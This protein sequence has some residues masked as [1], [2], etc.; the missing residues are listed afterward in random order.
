MKKVLIAFDFDGVLF[1]NL[2]ERF[3]VALNAFNAMGSNLKKTKK[4]YKGYLEGPGFSA[5]AS[6]LYLYFKLFF[7]K[8]RPPTKKEARQAKIIL[9]KQKEFFVKL[10]YLEREKLVK[11]IGLKK[12]VSLHKPFLKP[13][14]SFKK[15]V[16][17]KRFVV[18]IV[19]RKD[20]K[21]VKRLLKAFKINLGKNFVFSRETG[22]NK[23]E[24]LRK[25]CKTFGIPLKKT[26][27]ID[28][29]VLQ[30]FHVKKIGV[31][32]VL[33]GW[34]YASKQELKKARKKGVKVLP[35]NQIISFCNNFYLT[36]K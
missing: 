27:L 30:V 2:Y 12:W 28:D 25:A 35:K 16:Q 22:K 7:E 1:D 15:L 18:I 9:E 11:K 10:F 20:F 5:D 23:Q 26:I 32:P 21:S 36:V 19:T 8:K 31:T 6:D 4:L 24:Q 14:N 29:M 17:D 13:I 3:I 33:A 34:G